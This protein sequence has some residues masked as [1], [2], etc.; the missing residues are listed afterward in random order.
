MCHFTTIGHA[1]VALF[2]ENFS[3][4]RGMNEV[5]GKTI[6]TQNGLFHSKVMTRN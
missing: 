6:F 3:R 5:H 1:I 2:F 4:G